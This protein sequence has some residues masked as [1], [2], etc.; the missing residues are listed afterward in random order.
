MI[1]D[2]PNSHTSADFVTSLH[3]VN[4]E[5]PEVLDVHVIPDNLGTHETPQ[6]HRCL[7]TAGSVSTSPRPM[8]PG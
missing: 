7:A 5:V 1:T 2:I 8:D 6:V 3:K 4:R